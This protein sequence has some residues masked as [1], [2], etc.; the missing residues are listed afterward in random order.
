MRAPRAAAVFAACNFN[1]KFTIITMSRNYLEAFAILIIAF[2]LGFFLLLPKYQESQAAKTRVEEKKAEIKAR[3]DYYA[4][5]GAIM[6]DLEHYGE[7]ME[8]INT[9]LPDSL[10]A[11]AVMNFAKEAAMQAGLF[12]KGVDYSGAGGLSSSDEASSSGVSSL[13]SYS[14]SVK[15]T[16]TYSGLKNFLSIIERSSRLIAVSSVGIQAEQKKEGEGENN[17]NARDSSQAAEDKILDCDVKL[18]AHY[19]PSVNP[20]A[21]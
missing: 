2:A 12:V 20:S 5:L 14:I 15:L 19:Y 13:N 9:A 18:S 16:G 10:D 1:L 7:N 3:A 4:D 8:K 17:E 11:P 6:K 21:E